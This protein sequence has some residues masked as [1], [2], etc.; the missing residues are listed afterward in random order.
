MY[1]NIVEG[2]LTAVTVGYRNYRKKTTHVNSK[3]PPR[4]LENIV[5]YVM[6]SMLKVYIHH[7]N[8]TKC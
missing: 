6:A 5:Q 2:N 4:Q 8:A 7:A 3:T 1:I